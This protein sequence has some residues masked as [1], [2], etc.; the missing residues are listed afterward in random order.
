VYALIQSA[1][2]GIGQGALF[3]LLGLGLVLIH[4]GSNVINFSHAAVGVA[5]AYVFHQT[6]EQWLWPLPLAI[7]GTIAFVTVLAAAIHIGV[8]R[9][10]ASAPRLASVVATLGVLL[11]LQAGTTILFGGD[12]ILPRPIFPRG[13]LFNG[14]VRL[15]GSS[16]R[17]QD[18]WLLLISVVVALGVAVLVNH[19]R[20]GARIRAVAD[21]EKGAVLLGINPNSVAFASWWAGAMLAALAGI[22]ISPIIGLS[23]DT[24]TSLIVPALATALVGRTS[25]FV[26]TWAAGLGIGMAKAYLLYLVSAANSAYLEPGLVEAIPLVVIVVAMFLAGRTLPSRLEAV[27]QRPPRS[28]RVKRLA[29]PGVVITFAAVGVLVLVASNDW[30]SAITNSVLFAII[31]LSVVAITGLTGKVSLAQLAL[32]GVA[33]LVTSALGYHAGL[34]LVLVVPLATVS[35][36]PLG[37][38]V[39]LPAARVRGVNLAVVTLGAGVTIEQVILRSPTLSGGA[40]GSPVPSPRLFGWSIDSNLHPGR[41]AIVC[42]AAL[43]GVVVALRAVRR[44]GWGPR[45]LALRASERGASASG[46]D[47]TRAT[48]VMFMVAAMIAGLGGSLM[49]YQAG[50][51]SFSRFT[52]ASSIFLVAAVYVGGVSSVDGGLIAGAMATQGIV[53][54]LFTSLPEIEKY[55]LLLSGVLTVV[56]VLQNP[57][58]IAVTV[59]RLVRRQVAAYRRSGRGVAR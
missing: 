14:S 30:I 4:R 47:V 27:T 58:G 24:M 16:V 41:F 53:M 7:V 35:V 10:L 1:F 55:W 18:L 2:S 43:F 46:I 44:S 29:P 42:V 26:V 40:N 6:W 50:N 15:L 20:G 39:A 59:P 54:H 34:P 25:L 38:V 9:P 11:T 57:D 36:L 48:L 22:L 45:L 23:P 49:A 51:V 3:G 21:N 52:V 56:T 5:S 37:L 28:P 19:T 32:A 33:A 8:M 12:P 17:K 13:W 31:A